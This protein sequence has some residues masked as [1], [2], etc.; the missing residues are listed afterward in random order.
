MSCNVAVR[1][2]A[3]ETVP[4]RFGRVFVTNICFS[5]PKHVSKTFKDV[6]R[7]FINNPAL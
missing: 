4:S 2:A 3:D 1:K 6:P 7:V 5:S